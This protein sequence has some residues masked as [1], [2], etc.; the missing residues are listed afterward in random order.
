[1]APPSFADQGGDAARISDGSA[2]LDV[3]KHRF[4]E[5]HLILLART[6]RHHLGGNI[7]GKLPSAA[8]H[9]SKTIVLSE[10]RMV[11]SVGIMSDVSQ[12]RLKCGQYVQRPST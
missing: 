2:W 5:A 12:L 1:M 4:A 9:V 6:A 8:D 7:V 11:R 10:T 3:S